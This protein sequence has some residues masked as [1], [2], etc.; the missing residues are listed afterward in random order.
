MLSLEKTGGNVMPRKLLVGLCFFGA[1]QG[2]PRFSAPTKI[3]LG[4]ESNPKSVHPIDLEQDGDLDLLLVDQID[5]GPADLR[6]FEN[7][8]DGSMIE[9]SPLGQQDGLLA[10]Q[11]GDLNGDGASDLLLRIA[12]NDDEV[13]LNQGDGSFADP[14][15]LVTRVDIFSE[16][17]DVITSISLED[18]SL[19][20]V[21]NDG[22]LDLLG[23]GSILIRDFNAGE[24]VRRQGVALLSSNGDGTFA[25]IQAFGDLSR[26]ER[27][28]AGD[29]TGDGLMDAIISSA[30]GS[31]ALFA[32]QG[33]NS[34]ADPVTSDFLSQGVFP[35][36]D[37]VGVEFLVVSG[38]FDGD[39]DLDLAFSSAQRTDDFNETELT[40]ATALRNQG[41][42][43]FSN[44]EVLFER[45]VTT[46]PGLLAQD[47][48]GDGSAELIAGTSFSRKGLLSFVD[49]GGELRRA[50]ARLFEQ[51][52]S[53]DLSSL[54]SADLNGDGLPD[55][56]A[57]S[58]VRFI[59]GDLLVWFAK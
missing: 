41:G 43:S 59:G 37:I 19:V 57:V 55:L 44:F 27:F 49:R 35:I 16:A 52:I 9:R 48:D 15:P 17:E 5:L 38:D 58:A 33:G 51:G 13:L 28:T 54:I 53:V 31:A 25:P 1:C 23:R 30:S 3:F 56:A 29:F 45:D 32:N 12:G 4:D 18:S 47:F 34:F 11:P 39:Q 7:Q 10:V 24:S 6:L 50:R 21:D 40:I 8:G 20:D 36:D 2:A 26:G 14:L 46:N 42:G 22:D